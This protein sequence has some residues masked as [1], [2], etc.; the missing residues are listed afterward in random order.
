MTLAAVL[1]G[2]VFNLLYGLI[3]DRNSLVHKGGE[4]E[5]SDGLKCY[6]SA[7]LIT[8]YAGLAA[9]AITLWS[10]WHEKRV[11]RERQEE[12]DNDRIA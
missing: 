8:F 10:I 1:G 7:Y 5:C 6:S 3:Y 12:K 4:R 9:A 11:I 2:Y